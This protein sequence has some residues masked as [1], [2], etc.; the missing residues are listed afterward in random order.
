MS[1]PKTAAVILAAGMGTRMK[2]DLP[3]ALHPI[4]G[5]PMID[6]VLA[7]VAPLGPSERVVVVG[8]DMDIL[9]DAVAPC[10]AVVQQER[11]GTADAV[12]AARDTL[13]GFV[14]GTVYVLYGDTPLIATD[15]LKNMAAAREV[16]AAV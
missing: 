14:D 6:H 1:N 3:K 13:A 9:S 16:G 8:P 10:P 5:R 15:T 4:A 12:K 2:S 11:L 7:A